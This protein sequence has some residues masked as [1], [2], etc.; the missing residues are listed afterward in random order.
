VRHLAISLR[1]S[2]LVG[3]FLT[4]AISVFALTC[5]SLHGGGCGFAT[6]F[7]FI[8][9]L[10]GF[11]VAGATSDDL[12]LPIFLVTTFVWVTGLVFLVLWLRHRLLMRT[13][14]R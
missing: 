14:R 7:A 10:P 5:G 1:I 11:A 3:A 6:P 2:L 4:A 8:L 13:E 9:G 12:P